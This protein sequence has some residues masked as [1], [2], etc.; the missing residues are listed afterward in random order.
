[1]ADLATLKSRIASEL[2]RSDL[3]A[4]IASAIADAV[5]HYQTEPFALNQVRGSFNTVAGT[6]FY[7]NLTDV[8]SIDAVTVLV[9]AR[10]V[11]LDPWS[12]LRMEHINST[13]NTQSQPWAW[14]W[15]DEQ[16]R[17]YPVP[18]A[19]YPLTVSYTQKVGVPASD[20]D[21]N[22]WTTEAE[23]LIR[24]AAKKRICRDYTMDDQMG[25]RAEVAEREALARLKKNLNQLS[26]GGLRG[27]M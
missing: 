3:T 5:S 14:A 4:Q 6:E 1:M 27:S 21:S 19:V 22:I 20:G 9:N 25:M 7:N 18:D 2:H 17:L 12:Y 24:N 26:T 23:E 11:V 15:Y 13:T 10:K 16:I 8:A